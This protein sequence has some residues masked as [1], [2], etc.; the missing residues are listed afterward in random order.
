MRFA[1][2]HAPKAIHF[3]RGFITLLLLELDAPLGNRPQLVEHCLL[4][5]GVSGHQNDKLLLHQIHAF[6]VVPEAI[7]QQDQIDWR[8]GITAAEQG[9]RLQQADRFFHRRSET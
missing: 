3:Q 5:P 4:S 7:F 6:C 9:A 8:N 1:G 2:E